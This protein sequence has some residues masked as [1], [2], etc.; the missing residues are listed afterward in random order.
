[1]PG[2]PI[3]SELFQ[4][5][6][7]VNEIRLLCMQHGKVKRAITQGLR[8]GAGKGVCSAIVNRWAL[9]GLEQ[10]ANDPKKN[11]R[12]F[13][14]QWSPGGS[15]PRQIIDDQNSLDQ[16]GWME[17]TGI[18]SSVVIDA[19]TISNLVQTYPEGNS[20]P[21]AYFFLTLDVFESSDSHAIGLKR[22]KLQKNGVRYYSL[23]D[24]NY[25][26]VTHIL[27]L[28]TFM[29]KF[30]ALAWTSYFK[31]SLTYL[32]KR[33]PVPQFDNSLAREAEKQVDREMDDILAKLQSE[34]FDSDS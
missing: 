9:S 29:E 7:R 33:R 22:G 12:D 8:E 26:E 32:T 3:Q 28:A 27:D 6:Q 2:S 4:R 16:F 24:P 18:T 13:R 19:P 14:N 10:D 30:R 1:M 31:W 17:R 11:R 23:L 25:F 21:S 15:M 5:Q 20:Q 34:S